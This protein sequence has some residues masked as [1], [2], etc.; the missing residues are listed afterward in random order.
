[1]LFAPVLQ[2]DTPCGQAARAVASDPPDKNKREC[3]FACLPNESGTVLIQARQ[4][5]TKGLA[6]AAS[7]CG[8]DARLFVAWHL[9][10]DL[11]TA[12]FAC[13]TTGDRPGGCRLDM[14]G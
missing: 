7:A 9:L 10:G 11:V 13:R 6:S 5:E 4:G 8:V 2:H 14:T 1:M 3:N 12:C